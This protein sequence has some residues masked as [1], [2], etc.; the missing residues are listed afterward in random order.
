MIIH[1]N[2][3]NQEKPNIAGTYKSPFD[4][5]QSQTTI[6]KFEEKNENKK[7]IEQTIQNKDLS[8][9]E[10]LRQFDNTINRHNFNN[11]NN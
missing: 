4:Y 11:H 7:N 9:A 3:N 10:N 6:K 8:K 2:G 5:I 1:G